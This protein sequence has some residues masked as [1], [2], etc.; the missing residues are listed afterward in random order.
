MILRAENTFLRA[1]ND[2]IAATTS[3]PFMV[4][5][6]DLVVP[7]LSPC[8]LTTMRDVMDRHPDFGVL[9]IGLDQ[10]NLPSVQAPESINRQRSSTARSSRG[11][12][13]RSFR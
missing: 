8:W 7:E 5:D 4:T 1:L 13:A 2:G 6:P 12:L 9:G 11:R 10:S 3:D